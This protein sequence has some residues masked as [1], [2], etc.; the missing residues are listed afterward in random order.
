MS[1]QVPIT[2]SASKGRQN[3]ENPREDAD[4]RHL[5]Q[6]EVCDDEAFEKFCFATFNDLQQLAMKAILK[7]WVKELEPKK[8]KRFPYCQTYPNVDGHPDYE[9]TPEPGTYPDWWPIKS[10]IH[11]EPDHLSKDGTC[12]MLTI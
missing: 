8:Q 4:N 10:V 1:T 6:F 2:I 12:G 9:H 11:R 7:D 5:L 3:A